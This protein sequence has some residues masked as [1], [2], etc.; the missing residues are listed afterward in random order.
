MPNFSLYFLTK[1]GFGRTSYIFTEEFKRKAGYFFTESYKTSYLLTEEFK[2][3]AAYFFTPSYKAS[4]IFTDEFKRKAVYFL[5]SSYI[6]RYLFTEDLDTKDFELDCIYPSEVEKIRF[7]AV[8]LYHSLIEDC[9][10]QSI[11]NEKYGKVSMEGYNITGMMRILVDYLSSIWIEKDTDSRSGLARTANYYY[12]KYFINDII[13]N[14][15]DCGI[16]IKP[17]V[18]LFNLNSYTVID[19]QWPNYFMQNAVINP[20]QLGSGQ[21]KQYKDIYTTQGDI[22]VDNYQ[23]IYSLSD[24][25]TTFTPTKNIK[26]FSSFTVNGVDYSGYVDYNSNS[27]TYSPSVAFGYTIQRN[28]IVT[29]TYWYEE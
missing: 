3:R 21:M 22:E 8:K 11:A 13:L 18:A 1:E 24:A 10:K 6:S 7:K 2:R 28:D 23:S 17:I 9:L 15:R 20:P 5:T 27:V 14:F 16:N 12:T 26:Y 29:I 25:Q 19:S 4:Y